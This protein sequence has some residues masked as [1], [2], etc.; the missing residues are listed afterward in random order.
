MRKICCRPALADD[1]C[2]DGDDRTMQEK[3]DKELG[4][5]TS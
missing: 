5:S 1:D 3:V 4:D 2:D